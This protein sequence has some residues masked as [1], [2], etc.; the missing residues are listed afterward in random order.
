MI[1]NS[2]SFSGF[3][4]TNLGAGTKGMGVAMLC[5]ELCVT[6]CTPGGVVIFRSIVGR[7]R[8]S[9]GLGSI[10]TGRGSTICKLTLEG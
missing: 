1:K 8:G 5:I 2:C 10:W 7:D 9:E 6:F 3:M 4:T